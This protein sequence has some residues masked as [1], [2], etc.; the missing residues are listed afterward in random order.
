V[1]EVWEIHSDFS[2]V[3]LVRA[4]YV[5]NFTFPLSMTNT[6][7]L[8]VMPVSATLVASTTFLFPFS[9]GWKAFLCSPLAS[10]EW[11]ITTLVSLLS[12]NWL[13]IKSFTME[14][15]SYPGRNTNT[16]PSTC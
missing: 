12:K 11:R 8:R 3:V 6:T 5:F 2:M 4:S 7:S 10:W 15:S 13:P 16:G 14:M 9:G 1:L